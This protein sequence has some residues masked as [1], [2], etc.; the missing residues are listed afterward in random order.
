MFVRP[1]KLTQHVDVQGA[2]QA[3]TVV[4]LHSLGTDMHLWDPQM[5]RLTQRYRV[6]RLD[7]RGHGLSAVDAKPFSMSDLADD[8]VAV[9]DQLRIKEFYVA[10][11]SIGGTIAQWIGFKIPHRVSGMI[12]IDTSLVNAAPPALW[13]ARAE[14]VF[15]HGVEHL[16]VGILSRWVTPDFIHTPDADGMRQM[17]HRTSVEGF[18]GCSLAI[19]DSD[20]TNMN[21]PDVR[22]VVIRGS[23]DT[24][25]PMDYAQRLANKRN[26]ELHII[27]GAAHLPNFEKPDVLTDEIIAFI[28]NIKVTSVSKTWG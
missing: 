23:E 7:I 2:A 22:A 9:L 13:R 17:L 5:E 14:D 18:S 15:N 27:Q 11:V 19:A 3:P 16:E 25:T 28:E 26:A 12:I 21:I 20:L 10:G 4:L 6:V 24:L 8:V 1:L